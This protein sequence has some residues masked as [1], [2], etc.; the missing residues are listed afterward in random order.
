MTQPKQK[1]N[2][3]N[4]DKTVALYLRISKEGKGE[5]ESN[6][7]VN[8]KKLL[9]GISKKMGFSTILYFIDDGLT[10]TNRGRKEFNRML[11]ELKKGYIGAVMVKDLSRFA[12]DHILADTIIEEFFPEHDIRL[13]AVADG[14][15]TANGEDELVPFRNL[16]AEWYSRDI[17]KKR[18]L[19]NVVKG[20]AGEPLGPPPYG[21]MKDPANPKHWI[22]EPEAA[23]VVRRIYRMTMDGQG[24]EQIAAALDKDGILSP[25]HYWR[26]KG[27]NRGGLIT[28]ERP[29]KWGNTTILGI[30]R[31]QE[32]CGDVINFKTYSKSY[33]LKKR[34]ENSEENR[35]IFLDVHEPI[36]E[37]AVWEKVQLKRGKVRKRKTDSGEKCM[38]SGLIVCADC[39]SNLWY[40]FNQLNPEIKY[41]NCSNYKGNRGTCTSTHYIRVEFLEQVVLGEIRRMIRYVTKYGESFIQAA[42]GAVRQTAEQDRQQRQKELRKLETRDKELDRLFSRMY[43]DNATGKIDDDRFGRMSR[44]YTDEQKDL[45]G[46]IGKLRADLDAHDWQATTAENFTALLRKYSRVRKLT[47]YMLNELIDRIEVYQAEK[48]DGVW[49]QRLRIHYHGIGSIE[50]PEQLALPTPAVKMQTRKGVTVEYAPLQITP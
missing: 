25:M 21:Y 22:I 40:H 26:S 17:S 16:M 34:L 12:R 39:G 45:A 43:E 2:R 31:L 4:R 35:A 8:Q 24:I 29:S 20:N 13:I 3:T 32:Y 11:A 41:F 33:K 36:I 7:I 9:T 30:L 23:A 6:S 38:F 14:L 42:L 44:Q 15:D 37:R 28:D 47:P 46:R 49:Q 18:R 1:P 50:I 27:L 19:T 10:G 5:D 48:V